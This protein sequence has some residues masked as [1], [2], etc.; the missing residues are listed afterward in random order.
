MS[1]LVRIFGS[2]NKRPDTLHMMVTTRCSLGCP[3]CFYAQQEQAEWTMDQALELAGQAQKLG[4]KWL[5]IGGG[6]PMEWE[7]LDKFVMLARANRLKVAVT[8]NGKILRETLADR[9]HVSHDSMHV[10]DQTWEERT[11]E[12]HNA[13]DFYRDI[14]VQE[15]GMNILTTDMPLVSVDTL[16]RISCATIL[17]PK[18]FAQPP[19]GWKAHLMYRLE[20]WSQYCTVT[21]DSCLA[22]LLGQQCYQGRNSMSLNQHGQFSACSNIKPHYG[23]CTNLEQ[24][25]DL[26]RCQS[27]DRPSG[28]MMEKYDGTD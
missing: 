20:A 10:K 11:A 7:P 17:L 13:L 18:P 25:W 15:L 27:Q 12:V 5:A 23:H 22:V 21:V 2:S 26:T 9:V 3:G 14:G 16:Q 8:T 1:E 4:I 24:A 19:Q 28:C 6:E